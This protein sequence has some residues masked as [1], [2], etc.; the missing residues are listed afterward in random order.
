MGGGGER[1]S[2]MEKFPAQERDTNDPARPGSET[3]QFG[4]QS[5]AFSKPTNTIN[6]IMKSTYDGN[7]GGDAVF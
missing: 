2:V 6:Q 1:V 7:N 4:I 5:T 3:L